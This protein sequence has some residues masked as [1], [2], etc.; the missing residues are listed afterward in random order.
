MHSA[1]VDASNFLVGLESMVRTRMSLRFAR[2]SLRL[3]GSEDCENWVSCIAIPA[4][5]MEM[6]YP[7][8]SEPEE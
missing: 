3:W 7:L 5:D 8:K 2:C 6:D 1:F 4:M